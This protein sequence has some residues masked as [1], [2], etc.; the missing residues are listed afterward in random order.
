[1]TDLDKNALEVYCENFVIFRKAMEKVR[2]TTE[3]YK[4]EQGPK[5]NPWLKVAN[6]ASTQMKKYSEILL[7][8]PVSR[9]RVGL[10]KTK[11][12][13]EDPMEKLLRGG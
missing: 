11:A 4:S 5:I 9:A 7:L 2:E 8:D 6:D 10:A 3:V 1:M 13:E 12:E